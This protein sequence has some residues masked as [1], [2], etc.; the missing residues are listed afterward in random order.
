MAQ[1]L[2]VKLVSTYLTSTLTAYVLSWNAG[3][4]V[5]NEYT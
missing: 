4:N 1:L 5:T 3:E 2:A